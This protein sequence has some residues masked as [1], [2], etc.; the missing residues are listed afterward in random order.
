MGD[1]VATI[2]SV[3][4]C[5]DVVVRTR[6]LPKE[7][8]L[9]DASRASL[10]TLAIAMLLACGCA[11]AE[12][13]AVAVYSNV[14]GVCLSAGDGVRFDRFPKYPHHETSLRLSPAQFADLSSGLEVAGFF[15]DGGRPLPPFS[16]PPMAF[17]ICAKV[18]DQ[19]HQCTYYHRRGHTV[20]ERYLQLF[21][22]SVPEPH[23]PA[24]RKF[25][26]ANRELR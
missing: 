5:R 1:S 23:P 24:L 17:H 14:T 22:R 21:E 18:G 15:Q 11:S 6:A 12:H 2:R 10:C 9:I 4:Q 13:D 26:R 7:T 25:L 20:P 3:V 19:R 8:T 16:L